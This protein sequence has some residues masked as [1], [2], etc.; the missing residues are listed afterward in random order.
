MRVFIVIV[1]FGK[2]LC[3]VNLVLL[4]AASGSCFMI[5]ESMLQDLWLCHTGRAVLSWLD[6]KQFWCGMCILCY[7]HS[8]SILSFG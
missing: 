7:G 4:A 8:D 3:Q 1:A 2:L 5:A 6:E